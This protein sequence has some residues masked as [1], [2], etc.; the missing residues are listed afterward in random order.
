MQDLCLIDDLQKGGKLEE[1]VIELKNELY[2][3][4]ISLHK[5]PWPGHGMAHRN[6]SSRCAEESKRDRAPES[7]IVELKAH[8]KFLGQ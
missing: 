4:K 2:E 5:H 7:T 3:T 6:I 1:M 8:Q